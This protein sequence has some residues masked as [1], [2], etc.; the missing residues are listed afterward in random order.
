MNS[1]L[2]EPINPQK[3]VRYIQAGDTKGFIEY[4]EALKAKYEFMYNEKGQSNLSL[5]GLGDEQAIDIKE[6]V[7]LFRHVGYQLQS[8]EE[9]Q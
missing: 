4:Y 3:L 8:L 2:I 5:R 1:E 6:E 9:Q 7:Q